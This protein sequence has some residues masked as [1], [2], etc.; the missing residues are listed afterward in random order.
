MLERWGGDP[1]RLRNAA[2]DR[3]GSE[4]EVALAQQL[5]AFPELISQAARDRAPHSI[6]FYLREL[7]AVL[8]SCY[9]AQQFLVA[10]DDTLTEAR[11]ALVHATGI[12]L[13][14]GLAVLGVSAPTRM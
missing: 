1:D 3:L 14:Q 13:R 12:V 8:H 6:A 7:A 5:A 10:D 11:L 9:N 2:L 4:S